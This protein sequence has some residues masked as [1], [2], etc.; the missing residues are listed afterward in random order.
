MKR[1][2]QGNPVINA[3]NGEEALEIHAREQSNTGLVI[4]DLVP[5][6]GGNQCLE[7]LLK[8]NGM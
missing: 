6:M 8:I 1:D 2:G 5:Q 3:A 4:I 7:E